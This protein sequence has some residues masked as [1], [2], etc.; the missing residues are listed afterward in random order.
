M[1]MELRYWKTVLR[2]FYLQHPQKK[3]ALCDF[4]WL[5]A[6]KCMRCHIEATDGSCHITEFK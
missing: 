3:V 1:S 6:H 2:A 4:R 5:P